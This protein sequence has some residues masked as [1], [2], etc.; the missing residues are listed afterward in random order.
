M[1]P[2]RPTLILALLVALLTGGCTTR[3]PE[4]PISGGATFVPPT[5]PSLVIENFRNAVNEK[6]AANLMLCLADVQ[7][8]SPRA[9]AFTPS[10]EIGARYQ[11][12]FARWDVTAER[13][14][15]LSLTSRVPSEARL[16]LIFSNASFSITTPDSAVFVSD[17]ALTAPHTAPSLPTTVTGT[18][19][20]TILPEPSGLWSIAAWQDAKRPS[21]T[22][23]ATWSSWKAQLSN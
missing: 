12:L 4:D 9:Y 19:S 11:S 10:A 5:S 17:Y 15:F 14:A 6:N 7:R 2:L 8:P 18:L 1:H 23:E 20:F 3:T 21:D 13:Q 22:V 16:D